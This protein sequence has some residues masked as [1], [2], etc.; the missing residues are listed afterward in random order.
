V[1]YLPAVAIALWSAATLAA[2]T[3]PGGLDYGEGPLMDQAARLVRGEPL[4]RWPLDH[5]PWVVTNYP[6]LYMALLAG[7][8]R[9]AGQSLL[10]CGRL[11]T[12]TAAL[13]CAF[14]LR[15]LAARIFRSETAGAVAL[16]LFLL[17]PAVVIWSGYI[18]VDLVALAFALAAMHLVLVGAASPGELAAALL[19]LVAAAATKQT[20]LVAA[21]AACIVSLAQRS[22]FKAMLFGSAYALV[23]VGLLALAQWMTGGGFAR[24]VLL[25]NAN[26]WNP[27]R[28]LH[29]IRWGIAAAAPSL[30]LL[31]NSRGLPAA[32]LA[33]LL[34]GVTM[35]LLGGK[36][37]SHFNYL[38]E[39]DVALALAA[40]GAVNWL[41][42]PALLRRLA[43]VF[44]A[45]PLA[46]SSLEQ[47][48]SDR[49]AA[50]AVDAAVAAGAARG[51][52]ISDQMMSLAKAGL[53]ILYQPFEMHQL[54][55][56][57]TEPREL[58]D[59]LDR[60]TI[61]LVVLQVSDPV[62][63]GERWSPTFLTTLV[64]SYSRCEQFGEYALYR[65]R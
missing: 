1:K 34:A 13:T 33:F 63:L 47:R 61:S 57:A 49:A 4:Y 12:A 43:F 11:L 17:N 10:V 28:A 18:R 26:E 54:A 19:C 55:A 65:P 25:A 53:S 8:A 45:L 5:A 16:V 38:L 24:H 2:L 51:P 21:P 46:T 15:S 50:R 20:Y 29:L 36:V 32:V 64:R 59:A 39:A 27:G 58:L 52:V 14:L 60:R 7:L 62:L 56:G 23:L 6:P 9:I 40:A 30:L 22:R 37:G 31:P 42:G 48:I 3:F 41:A 35:T 44:I